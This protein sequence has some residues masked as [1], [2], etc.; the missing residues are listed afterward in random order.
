MVQNTILSLFPHESSGRVAEVLGTHHIQLRA[1]RSVSGKL[2]DFRPARNGGKHQ[3]SLNAR[4]NPYATLLVFLHELAHLLVWKEHGE[5][6]RP[7]GKEWKK[8]FGS[9]IRAWAAE[10]LFHQSLQ[11]VLMPYAKRVKAT[12]LGDAALSR[13]LGM[14]D[15]GDAGDEDLVFLEDMPGDSLFSTRNGRAFR[16]M[17]R[18]RTRYKC[19]CMDNRRVYLFHPMT[20]VKRVKAGR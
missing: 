10:G 7:H 1:K 12:G 13:A 3:I 4:L 11:A 8:C 20:R 6:V 17:D 18:V 19:L 5:G 16:K 14:F 9:L 15:Q 2:G